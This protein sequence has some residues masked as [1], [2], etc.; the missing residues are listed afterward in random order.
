MLENLPAF[1][2]SESIAEKTQVLYIHSI[3]KPQ[4]NRSVHFYAGLP[5]V[6]SIV[7]F[8]KRFDHSILVLD[9]CVEQLGHLSGFH[10]RSYE[11]LV[12][13]VARK[14]G[15]SIIFITQTIFLPKLNFLH[16]FRQSSTSMTIFPYGGNVKSVNLLGSQIAPNHKK[17]YMDAY[18][19]AISRNFGYLH[20][21]LRTP[22]EGLTKLRLRNFFAAPSE[23]Y[24]PH[25]P[26]D[27]AVWHMNGENYNYSLKQEY[28]GATGAAAATGAN[29]QQHQTLQHQQQQ[30]NSWLSKRGGR[31]I[32]DQEAEE[33]GR[34]LPLTPAASTSQ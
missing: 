10:Q 4:L 6:E 31:I 1:Y 30:F 11:N 17:L 7:S 3:Q 28:L 2:Q 24:I 27:L 18:E 26:Q 34:I 23:K 25:L 8:A 15:L 22:G 32:E 19:D 20:C 12:T 13:D 29:L 9:D 5:T 14:V 33:T 16:T 21:G